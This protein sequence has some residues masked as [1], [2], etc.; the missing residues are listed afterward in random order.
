MLRQVALSLMVS[1]YFGFVRPA[2]AEDQPFRIEVR[3]I[4]VA[5]G[6]SVEFTLRNVSAAPITIFEPDLPWIHPSSHLVALPLGRQPLPGRITSED[7]FRPPAARTIQPGE[8]IVGRTALSTEFQS[9]D[10][11]RSLAAGRLIVFW[12][13][14]PRTTKDDPLGE[15]GGWIA[16]V[17]PGR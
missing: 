4:F 2:V 15:Y 7:Y 12:Y 9:D 5:D 11:Q 14:A 8:A 16:L 10:L 13:Y 17:R 3:P 6:P 1:L